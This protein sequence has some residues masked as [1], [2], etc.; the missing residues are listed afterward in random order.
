MRISQVAEGERIKTPKGDR[1]VEELKCGDEISQLGNVARLKCDPIPHDG[2]RLIR[3]ESAEGLSVLVGEKHAFVRPDWG[4]FNAEEALMNG[5]RS[6]K[7]VGL[8]PDRIKDAWPAGIGKVFEIVTLE[9]EGN[10][11]YCASGFWS[12]S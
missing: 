5:W 10:K 2:M 11:T 4:Y 7:T 12:L 9:G 3:V 1:L 6:L 8:K